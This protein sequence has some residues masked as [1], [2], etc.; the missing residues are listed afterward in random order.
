MAE[1]GRP[2]RYPIIVTNI[3]DALERA[4]KEEG[5]RYDVAMHVGGGDRN[6]GFMH[7]TADD[8][9]HPI[10]TANDYWEFPLDADRDR[11]TRP[12]IVKI[13]GGTE[14]GRSPLDHNYVLTEDD[15]IGYMSGQP[16]EGIVPTQLKEKLMSAHFLFIGHTM[17]DWNLR[18]FLMQAVSGGTPAS[19]LGHPAAPPGHAAT[20]ASGRR[21]GRK[22][23][24][25]FAQ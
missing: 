12:V 7:L 8:E 4:F 19:I 5:E 11:F 3:Y 13:H 6:K 20:S 21:W 16:I 15:Y 1:S 9:L 17:R 10:P 22:A 14:S 23:S 18:I 24:P 2:D 25:S